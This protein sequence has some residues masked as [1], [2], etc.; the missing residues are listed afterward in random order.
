MTSSARLW[1]SRKWYSSW[2]INIF[3]IRTIC[4]IV[5][6]Y[7]Y[8]YIYYF[9][10]RVSNIIPYL[11]QP[12]CPLAHR[13]RLPHARLPPVF[14]SEPHVPTSISGSCFS[15]CEAVADAVCSWSSRVAI[16]FGERK[17]RCRTQFEGCSV[18]IVFRGP[19]IKILLSQIEKW[20]HSTLLSCVEYIFLIKHFCCILWFCKKICEP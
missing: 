15:P 11:S 6:L 1:L 16:D 8:I 10:P 4:I 20:L 7:I 12:D 19:Q 18:N 13:G 5:T 14:S 3:Y 2:W 17:H 9:I